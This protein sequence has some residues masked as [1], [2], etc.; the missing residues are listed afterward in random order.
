MKS[1]RVFSVIRFCEVGGW[2]SRLVV[3]MYWFAIW[4]GVRV[5]FF[6]RRCCCWGRRC[7]FFL[8][9]FLY[10][11]V[12]MVWLLNGGFNVNFLG[13]GLLVFVEGLRF[14]CVMVVILVGIDVVIFLFI[15]FGI[16]D[17]V[18]IVYNI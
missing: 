15:R 3:R 6:V 1:L 4:R 12:F 7:E 14:G 17:I 10:F 8:L 5:F 18:R 11:R 13:E 2:F 16:V 9:I